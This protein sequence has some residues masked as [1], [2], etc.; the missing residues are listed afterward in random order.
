MRLHFRCHAELPLGSFLRVTGSTLWAPGTAASDPSDAAPAVGRVEESAFPVTEEDTTTS[1]VAEMSALYTSSV[2][3]VT[4]PEEYPV[5]RTRVP[6]AVVIHHSRRPVQ[7]HFYRYL[8]VCPGGSGT[9]KFDQHIDSDEVALLVS[10]SN[11]NSGSTPVM[12][13]EDPF[14]TL[15]DK[16]SRQE[17]SA[18]SLASVMTGGQVTKTD[19]RNLPYRTLDIDVKTGKAVFEDTDEAVRLDRWSIPDDASF[20]N[21]RIREAVRV[22]IERERWCLFCFLRLCAL[23]HYCHLTFSFL[24]TLAL[25]RRFT[26]KTLANSGIAWR[27]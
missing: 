8:V 14:G 6:V 9:V 13:W 23:S 27:A 1:P 16:G 26:K 19:Y 11:E 4:T 20:R 22:W 25:V 15:R 18:V 2:E 24:Y 17:L 21:Y 5:W 7:H 10:T 12:Q 3:M